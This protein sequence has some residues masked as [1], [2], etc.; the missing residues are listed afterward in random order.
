MHFQF[1]HPIYLLLLVPA[2][3]WVFWFALKSDVQVGAWRKW[4]ALVVRTIVVLAIVFAIAGLQRLSPIEGMNVFFVLDRSDS[5]PAQQQEMAKNYINATSKMKKKPD[6][7]GVIVF[8]SEASIES[9]PNSAVDLQKI[10]AVV[11]TERTDL[12]AAI[13]LGTAAFPEHG[14]KRLVLMSDGNENLGDAMSAVMAG[15]ELGMSVDILEMGVSRANDVSVEKLQ[16]P[17]QVKKGQAF[18]VKIFIQ[19]DH[20]GPAT[21]RLYRKNQFLGE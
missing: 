9:T 6:K 2:L 20:A 3:A 7:A 18:E 1:T 11:G 13:R 19:A 12:A 5:V 14:Q 21:V 17:A 16:L 10:Q 15:K 8:G 4:T